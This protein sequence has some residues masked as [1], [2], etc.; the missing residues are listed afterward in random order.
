MTLIFALPVMLIVGMVSG[1]NYCN[2]KTHVCELGRRRHFMCQLDELTPFGNHTKFHAIIPDTHKVIL[3]TLGVINTFRN[4]FAGGELTTKEN[5]TFSSAKRMRRLNWDD[6]L[7]YMAR[8]HASTVSFKHSECRATV[9]F[10]MAGECLGLLAPSKK[11]IG[12]LEL[13]NKLF[14]PMFDEYKDVP[15]PDGLLQSFDSQR[16]YN[17]GHFS[18]FVSDRVSHIGCGIAV[19]S[20]CNLNDSA[21]S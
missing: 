20:N 3:E 15:D 6:E 17:V 14:S 18:L 4:V 9:R 21:T 10:P 13:L 2:N 16:D 1:Y 5:K 19:G 7:A 12:L 8:T 11:K